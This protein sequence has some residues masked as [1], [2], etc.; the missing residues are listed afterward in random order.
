M[1]DGGWHTLKRSVEAFTLALGLALP[2]R[3]ELE[4][5]VD[6]V[7]RLSGWRVIAAGDGTHEPPHFEGD[8]VTFFALRRRSAEQGPPAVGSK[9]STFH[10]KGLW[11]APFER[12]QPRPPRPRTEVFRDLIRVVVDTHGYG[13]HVSVLE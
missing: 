6:V 9:N 12:D 3:D 13:V 4:F 1:F 10:Q 7:E 2:A 8:A 11:E 5:I